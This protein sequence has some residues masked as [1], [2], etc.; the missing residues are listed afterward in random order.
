MRAIG[1]SPVKDEKEIVRMALSVAISDAST[2]G[3][4]RVIIP[5]LEDILQYRFK[6]GTKEYENAL[7]PN[8]GFYKIYVSGLDKAL[9]EIQEELPDISIKLGR[10]SE[11]KDQF[12]VIDMSAY[13]GQDLSTLK[14]NEGGLA[15]D[16]EMR[17]LMAEG[18]LRDDGMNVDPISG[19]EVPY[20]SL[21]EE[22]RDDI[23]AQLSEGE[24]VV[25]A[26]VVR[27]YGVKY[28]EDLRTR[29][30]MGLEDMEVNGRIGGE[31]A[32]NM[33]G[34]TPKKPMR[35]ATGGL[36]SEMEDVM[37]YSTFDPSKFSTVGGSFIKRAAEL[38]S[39]KSST[40][41]IT[42]DDI[43]Y[44]T[45]VSPDGT[46]T[47]VVPIINGEPQ[48]TIPDG[49]VTQEEYDLAE[50]QKAEQVSQVDARG[51][52]E[53][54][55]ATPQEAGTTGWEADTDF[56][57]FTDK[58]WL[59]WSDKQGNNFL[60]TGILSGGVIG[61]VGQLDAVA[62]MRSGLAIAAMYG[63]SEDTLSA[64][65]GKLKEYEDRLAPYEKKI[66]KST[67]IP[68]SGYKQVLN[69]FEANGINF[70]EKDANTI[71]SLME[72]G[73]ISNSDLRAIQILGGTNMEIGGG[74]TEDQF[75]SPEEF[76]KTMEDVAPDGM[77]YN[78][79]TGSYTQQPDYDPW[80]GLEDE[81][82]TKEVTDAGVTVYTNDGSADTANA[83]PVPPTR[84]SDLNTNIPDT[85]RT[86]EDVQAE[87]NQ[88]LKDSDGAWTEE[89]NDLVA[90]RED[91]K[92]GTT[93]TTAAPPKATSTSTSS[94]TSGKFG[95]NRAELEAAG[96]T[97]SADGNSVYLN[98]SQVAGANWSGSSAVN[99]I[100]SGGS[101]SSTSTNTST[102]PKTSTRSTSTAPKKTT[103]S[104]SS[105]GGGLW[106]AVFGKSFRDT[107]G[108]ENGGLVE[109]PKKD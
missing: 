38:Q 98:G 16:N 86:V 19:N 57:S 28:F 11:R 5:S 78:P 106:K 32:M 104:S 25:P 97:V 17:A 71:K 93:T 94:G 60:S 29:A 69:H 89:L 81:G 85:A 21:A 66:D 52:T 35:M 30:K 50:A 84:P 56:A 82:Y 51:R 80:A 26:D 76:R 87:I 43:T 4:N 70:S 74:M 46:N 47:I 107:I 33:G 77:D 101:T 90:E 63:A 36:S 75:A 8:S 88:A 24:Y 96:Y 55:N 91:L 6:P 64:M 58:D 37:K 2:S 102:A 7:K 59:D 22:V 72:D 108:Y 14:F 79:E 10:G 1:P 34:M 99:N 27:Y 40:G 3:L 42:P 41:G 105:S 15:M 45:Y 67:L 31:P 53:Q 54:T 44:V 9:K 48:V 95:T 23:P 18:G 68:T 73:S 109:R 100:V 61:T 65:E 12:T 92:A 62:D 49:Y 83:A 39:G 20:G 13:T 103:T